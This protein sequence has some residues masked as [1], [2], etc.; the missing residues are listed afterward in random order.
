MPHSPENRALHIYAALRSTRHIH[1]PLA[2][3]SLRSAVTA[4][5]VAALSEDLGDDLAPRIVRI[6]A[7][8]VPGFGTA[9]TNLEADG[10]TPTLLF[11]IDE[12]ARG[13]YASGGGAERTP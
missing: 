7:E 11:I 4:A 5:I 3:E 12:L 13:R 1:V 9:W 6:I 2:D 10:A 8:R